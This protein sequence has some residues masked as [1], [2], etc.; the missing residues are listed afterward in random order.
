[1][2]VLAR[3]DLC[4][5]PDHVE[6]FKKSRLTD[7][8]IRAAGIEAVRPHDIPRALGQNP[9]GVT[10][11]Y[12]IPYRGT[13]FYR[14]KVFPP[15]KNSDG[16]TI[17]YLQLSTPP[18][19]YLPPGV[20]SVLAD[21]T[22]PLAFVEGEKKTLRAMQEGIPS[23]GIGGAWNWLIEGNPL[24]DLDKIAYVNR[25]ATIY[26]DSDLW[27]RPQVMQAAYALGKEL[28]SRG[29]QVRVAVLTPL[30]G[31]RR[32]LDDYEDIRV[33]QYNIA[34]VDYISLKHSALT[35]MTQWY[36]G[37]KARKDK[38]PDG[39]QGQPV[40]QR[41]DAPWPEPVDGAMLLS[42][43]AEKVKRHLVMPNKA[44]D[45]VALWIIQTYAIAVMEV[46]PYLAVTS[47]VL[48]EGKTTLLELVAGLCCRPLPTVNIS[49]A[50]LYRSIELWC[51]AIICDEADKKFKE[52][53]DLR[54]LFNAGHTRATAYV[55]RTVGDDH[56][57]RVFAVF[58][59]KAL[60]LIGKLPETMMDRSIEVRMQ[61]KRQDQKTERMVRKRLETDCA[62]L[63]QQIVR[64]IADHLESLRIREDPV[65]PEELDDRAQDNWRGLLAIAHLAGGE[66]PG[67][68][69]EAACLLSGARE[70]RGIRI[71]L[72]HDIREVFEEAEVKSLATADIIRCLKARE[73]RP[74]ATYSRKGESITPH[75]LAHLLGEIKIKPDKWRAGEETIRGYHLKDFEKAFA[76]YLPPPQSA[77]S[78]IIQH[79]QEVMQG[80]E[81]PHTVKLWRFE[82]D[83]SP[84]NESIV[85]DVADEGGGEREGEGIWQRLK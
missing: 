47:A 74:W 78:A 11:A 33:D 71:Q 84:Q 56:E 66:W 54:T 4:L 32:G 80:A 38:Q 10:S 51:P 17:K 50:A 8:T 7:A 64:W 21:P 83:V 85:A 18:R 27:I 2:S 65:C 76:C 69:H 26:M 75:A 9:K 20:E 41:Q 58:G 81:A 67:R 46:L 70:E 23:V 73:E 82:D 60:G 68:A 61:R 13:D 6:D 72:L 29:A 79:N 42:A 53:D 35:K 40:F 36:K 25:E 28:E 31:N 39:R 77:T 44:E 3:I 59:A 24:P 52:N 15:F 45:A 12:K 57:P 30:D 5:H 1:M 63:R 43:I 19:L 49:P 22:V 48:R 37:W 16:H 62:P 14:C 34:G 55:I